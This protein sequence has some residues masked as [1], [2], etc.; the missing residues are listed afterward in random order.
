MYCKESAMPSA[1]ARTPDLDQ[2]NTR[3]PTRLSSLHKY[4][5]RFADTVL[6]LPEKHTTSLAGT[7]IL[8]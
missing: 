4:T 6:P 1:K 2:E 3:I 5:H 8:F 7:D